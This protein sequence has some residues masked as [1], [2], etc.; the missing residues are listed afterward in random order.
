MNYSVP[1]YMQLLGNDRKGL[2]LSVPLGFTLV[3]LE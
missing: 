1:R 2:F 3:F